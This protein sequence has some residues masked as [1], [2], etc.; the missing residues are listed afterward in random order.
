MAADLQPLIDEINAAK[1]VEQSAIEFI[2]GV[3]A[4]IQAA[5]DAA[6]ANGATGEQLAPVVA[7]GDELKAKTDEL[8][9]ALANNP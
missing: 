9:A 3:A 6:L 7:V 8:A 1:G 4:K 5:V 2:N